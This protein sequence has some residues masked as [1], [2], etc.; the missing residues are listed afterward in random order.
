MHPAPKRADK[1]TVAEYLQREWDSVERHTYIDGELF[2]MAGES[3]NHGD[4]SVNL[5]VSIGSQLKGTPC[6]AK[7]KDTKVRSS[8]AGPRPLRDTAG[9]F[10]Y[11]DVVVVCGEPE[12]MDDRSAIIMNPTAIVE[13]LSPSTKAFDRGEKFDRFQR[14]NPTLTDYLLVTQDKP[15]VEHF[16][17]Q[18]DGSWRYTTTDG[19]DSVVP[20]PSIGCTLRLADVYDRV[21][22]LD[23][24]PEPTEDGPP[25]PT[26]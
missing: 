11:P 12:Y 26:E 8:P 14:W 21:T 10:S 20:V 17:R 13:V 18:P 22:F 16:T 5:V 23:P 6:R 25:A 2:A 7:T 3:G 19:L 24:D 1:V 15:R 4:I 9:L